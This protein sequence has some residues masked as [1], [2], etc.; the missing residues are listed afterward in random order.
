MSLINVSFIINKHAMK[1]MTFEE[2][3]KLAHQPI[4]LSFENEKS[5][6]KLISMAYENK[7][8]MTEFY[9]DLFVENI[10]VLIDNKI[11]GACIFEEW[12]YNFSMKTFSKKFCF[13]I[14]AVAY[15]ADNMTF[16]LDIENMYR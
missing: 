14:V 3:Y 4:S 12:N 13:G 7:Q 15:G 9:I 1:S 5:Q 11:F 8:A 2:Y 10:I 6:K 16:E